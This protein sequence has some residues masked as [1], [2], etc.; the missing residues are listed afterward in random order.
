ME[1][2]IL[3]KW[4]RRFLDLAKFVSSWSK[5]P[6]TKVGAVVARRNRI[7][8]VGFNGFASGVEDEGIES[9]PRERKYLRT[10]HAEENA[11]LFAGRNIYGT[12][13]YVYP[14]QP[15]SNCASKI[16]QVGIKKVVVMQSEK[17][18][19]KVGRWK[20]SFNEAYSQFQEA[21]VV[22]EE[23]GPMWKKV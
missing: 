15:C 7:I 17:Q 22:L 23:W 18:S 20:E 3:T 5:D 6:S 19:S 9:M 12:T 13:I 8:S 14:F 11:I 10:I 4:D 16:I 2:K 21:G 1:P